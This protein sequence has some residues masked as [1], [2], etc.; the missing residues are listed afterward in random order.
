MVFLNSLC[1]ESICSQDFWL[2]SRCVPDTIVA[3]TI[4]TKDQ[5]SVPTDFG[6][7]DIVTAPDEAYGLGVQLNHISNHCV[8]CDIV[9]SQD[10]GFVD[11]PKQ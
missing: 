6:D 5:H 11:R 2:S 7:R 4:L 10:A 8:G 3:L 9:E 1:Q